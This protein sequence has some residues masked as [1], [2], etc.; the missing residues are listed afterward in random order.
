MVILDGVN[1][2]QQQYHDLH[3]LPLILPPRVHVIISCGTEE[4][5][6]TAAK[7]RGF[8]GAILYSW[9][10]IQVLPFEEEERQEFITS[11]LALFGKVLDNRDIVRLSVLFVTC[12]RYSS[13]NR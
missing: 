9:K 1:Q 6:I 13:V 12:D 5:I 11:M 7:A 4:K 3:W 2:L 10:W 8:G